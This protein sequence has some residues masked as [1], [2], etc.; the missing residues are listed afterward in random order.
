MVVAI[1]AV[2]S[3]AAYIE[4]REILEK[5]VDSALLSQA[6]AVTASLASDDSLL[7]ARKEIQAFLGPINDSKGPVYRVWFEGEQE[8]YIDSSSQ[9][10]WP[11]DWIPQSAETPVVGEHRLFNTRRG[12]TPYRLMWTRHPDPRTGLATKEPLNIVI[13]TYNGY[14]SDQ[15]GDFLRVL[16]ILG[17]VIILFS[18][19]ATLWILR[20]GMKPVAAITAIMDDITDKNLSEPLSHTTV[21]PTELRPFVKAWD[22]MI[23][24]LALAMQQQ[25]RFTADASHELRTPLAIVKSTLQ[26]ARSRKRSAD[27]YESAI[28]Q[29]LEDLERLEHLSEQLLVLAHLDDIKSQ[30]ERETVRL[31]DLVRGVCQQYLPFARQQGGSL[32]WQVCPAKV[33]GSYEQL[34]RLFGNLVDNAVKYGP[35]GGEVSVSMR[36]FNGL[37][38]V[39]V[40]DQ[41]GH[42]PKREQKHIFDRF[43][44]VRKTHSRASTGSGLGLALAQEI[45][46]RHLGSIT[47]Q[48]NAKSGTDFVV[49]LPLI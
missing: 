16:L 8:N 26:A 9:E 39:L 5:N 12:E 21:P 4:F 15:I 29:S 34:R 11:L 13:A 33:N 6:E 38:N 23:E 1:I 25:R 47:V 45:A 30:S 36:C 2:L 42:I 32:K 10:D 40:H 27:A 28:D 17:I 37:V 49:S 41:G 14:I 24:R 35:R 3:T 48:S 18:M 43:Y 20:W 44:R 46:Q 7:E 31:G 19:G 22:Q